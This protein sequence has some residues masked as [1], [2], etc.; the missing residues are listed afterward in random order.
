MK[1]STVRGST[2]VPRARDTATAGHS[3]SKATGSAHPCD[4][5]APDQH[6]P[7]PRLLLA[8]ALLANLLLLLLYYYPEAKFLVGDEGY[9]YNLARDRAAGL[10]VHH[11][12]L[13]PA[14]Y[15]QIM[16]FFFK[17]FGV[18]ILAVQI[19]Q[20][21]LWFLAGLFLF[22]IALTL[23]Q[24]RTAGLWVLGLY[25]FSPELMAFSHLLW[26]ETIHI[27]FFIAAF[28]LLIHR[29]AALWSAAGAGA[30]LGLALL[31][32][33]LLLPFLPVLALF[34]FL[35]SPGDRF[36]RVSRV[37]LLAG[38]LSLTVLPAM[39]HNQRIHGSFVIADSSWF[40]LWVGLYDVERVDYRN[41]I[42]NGAFITYQEMASDLAS[43]N[44][45][46]REQIILL[47]Q[48]K[49][50]H[51]ILANQI[52]KQY[53]RLLGHQTFFT[54]QLAGGPRQSYRFDQP[55]LTWLL[56]G[57]AYLFHGCML[58]LSILGLCCLRWRLKSWLFCLS[59]LLLFN[60]ALFLLVHVKTRYLVQIQPL[61]LLFGGAFLAAIPARWSRR[62]ESPDSL[63]RF[64]AARLAM[65]SLLVI[66]VEIVA[67]WAALSPS[68]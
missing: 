15:G 49:G 55:A 25:L 14:L 37:F 27:F 7:W 59:A 3:P 62:M 16:T 39:V 26:P 4:N 48:K 47:V 6:S 54:T 44:Q 45:F 28:W 68:A 56:R 52:S 35:L 43:R 60:L 46:C 63:F 67:F 24:S 36:R 53:F 13:W 34:M 12:P 1:P 2:N 11:N 61:L 50:L 38:T 17:V 32:K 10:Q 9:Y 31:S 20:V 66:A 21:L 33:L 18:K 42:A 8:A 51:A 30:L 41:D 40:N 5:P 64:S 29:P 58:A 65:G 22:Q 23:F 19:L 57:Y